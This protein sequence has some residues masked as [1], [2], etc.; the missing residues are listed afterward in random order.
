MTYSRAGTYETGTAGQGEGAQGAS[1]Q[2]KEKAGQA[3]DQAKEKAGQAADQAKGRAR[4]EV[5]TRSTQAGEQVTSMAEAFRSTGDKL[6]EEGKDGPAKAADRAAQEAQKV[7]SYLTDSDSDRI[8]S[9][10]EDFARSKP[11]AVLAG[12]VALGIV[13]ARFLK[14]SSAGRASQNAAAGGRTYGDAGNGTSAGRS[15]GSPGSAPEA[16]TTPA[17]PSTMPPG[18]SAPGAP[19]TGGPSPAPPSPPVPPAGA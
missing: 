18:P 15:F 1:D 10:A 13:A 11:W 14:A 7:G 2:A 6:R 4:E 3:A 9:D 8:L 16:P 12:G 5:D 19:L 17:L